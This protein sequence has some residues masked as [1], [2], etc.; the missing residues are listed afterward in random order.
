M[1]FCTHSNSQ[2]ARILSQLAQNNTKNN[3]PGKL[4]EQSKNEHD[5]RLLIALLGEI[6]RQALE[7]WRLPYAQRE[8]LAEMLDISVNISLNIEPY[9]RINQ[10]YVKRELKKFE[11]GTLDCFIPMPIRVFITTRDEERESL[12]GRQKASPSARVYNYNVVDIQTKS[13]E[14]V[15]EIPH[16]LGASLLF[17]HDFAASLWGGYL[18]HSPLTYSAGIRGQK[19]GAYWETDNSTNPIVVSWYS[20]EW[21]TFRDAE[22]FARHWSLHSDQ[23]YS[24]YGLAWLAALLEVAL[25]EECKPGSNGLSSERLKVFLIRLVIE[26]THFIEPTSRRKK[27]SK[28]V[29][30]DRQKSIRTAR[31]VLIDSA[32]VAIALLLAPESESDVNILEFEHSEIAFFQTIQEDS[33]LRNKILEVRSRIWCEAWNNGIID[34]PQRAS[35]CELIAPRLVWNLTIRE[36]IS[37]L[38]DLNI[39]DVTL[40]SLLNLSE[41]NESKNKE[42]SALKSLK[43]SFSER[44]KK[45]ADRAK[46]K[47]RFDQLLKTAQYCFDAMPEYPNTL[48]TSQFNL[49]GDNRA[50]MP[51]E[52]D[53]KRIQP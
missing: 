51:T 16:R 20:P 11:H 34:T 7:E 52:E 24:Q 14:K 29:K 40:P 44:C 27:S 1:T 49:L 13:E 2:R 38:M 50:F 48:A 36:M 23:S 39:F 31:H 4:D 9:L 17:A 41:P 18:Q 8:R 33:L 30:S 32:L 46:E 35:L 3:N 6:R 53:I 5:N 43:K 42:L 22:R 28:Q 47:D 12:A 10:N 15:V 19:V 45:L 25:N 21:W 37:I 26:K